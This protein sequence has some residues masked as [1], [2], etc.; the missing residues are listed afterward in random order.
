MIQATCQ[1]HLCSTVLHEKVWE[2][3]LWLLTDAQRFSQHSFTWAPCS[4]KPLDLALQPWRKDGVFPS[5][6]TKEYS[7]LQTDL[8]STRGLFRVRTR[9][10]CSSIPFSSKVRNT[11]KKQAR[12]KHIG[13]C[14]LPLCMEEGWKID[15]DEHYLSQLQKSLLLQSLVTWTSDFGNHVWELHFGIVTIIISQ[16]PFVLFLKIFF[17]HQFRITKYGSSK[18][19]WLL[20]DMQAFIS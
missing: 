16:C 13:W 15:G 14:Q 19:D 11:H 7:E 10:T 2:Q 5:V 8:P 20:H 18:H 1:V 4:L 6:M 3:W 17:F 9:K 12:N